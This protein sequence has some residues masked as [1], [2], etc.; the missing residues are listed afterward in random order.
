MLNFP[1]PPKSSNQHRNADD[2]DN[3]H[4][5][6]DGFVSH[7]FT[8]DVIGCDF[9]FRL[10][11]CHALAS[12]ASLRMLSKQVSARFRR[13]SD[14]VRIVSPRTDAVSYA[15]VSRKKRQKEYEGC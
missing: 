9:Q 8:A 5:R 12:V 3:D 13:G 4:Q 1:V 10:L 11:V 2:Q 7:S 14:S 6:Y 15:R